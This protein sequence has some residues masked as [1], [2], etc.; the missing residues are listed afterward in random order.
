[1]LP[2]VNEPKSLWLLGVIKGVCAC[3]C[4]LLLLP[5]ETS[6]YQQPG[7]FITKPN[8]TCFLIFLSSSIIKDYITKR[9]LLSSENQAKCFGKT[10][11]VSSKTHTHTQLLVKSSKSEK[12]KILEKKI[13]SILRLIHKYLSSYSTL[14]K[15]MLE[16]ISNVLRVWFIQERSQCSNPW[17]HTQRKRSWFCHKR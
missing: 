1:M 15:N 11:K 2:M 9:E 6:T 13:Q 8:Y 16:I 7:A 10:Q 4:T 3:T 12:H 5:T 17:I 14:M